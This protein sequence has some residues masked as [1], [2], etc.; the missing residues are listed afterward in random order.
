MFGI[1]LSPAKA[2]KPASRPRR[3]DTVQ[4]I[5]AVMRIVPHLGATPPRPVGASH[6]PATSDRV[7]PR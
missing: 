4:P 1:A 7:A 3:Q 6:Q 2:D 5:R